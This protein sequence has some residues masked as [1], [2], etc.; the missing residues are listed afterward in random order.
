[1]ATSVTR[2]ILFAAGGRSYYLHRGTDDLRK[3]DCSDL[4]GRF[5]GHDTRDLQK[6]FDEMCLG[7]GIS[8]DDFERALAHGVVDARGPQDTR[9]SQNGCHSP[10]LNVLCSYLMPPV[11]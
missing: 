2:S 3:I 8:F 7:A 10:P 6:V 5:A 11:M 9:P 1:M 4:E